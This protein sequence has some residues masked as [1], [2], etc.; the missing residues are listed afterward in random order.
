[1]PMPVAFF[2]AYP[3]F[4]GSELLPRILERD[5]DLAAVCVVQPKFASLARARVQAL[6]GSHPSLEGRVRI[7]EGDITLPSLGLD[8]HLALAAEVTQIFHLAAVYDLSV[9]RELALR[10]NVEGTRNVIRFAR[11]CPALQRLQ[12]V[13]TCYVSGRY[14]G[15]FR[16]SQLEEG[17]QFNN[18][19]EET[20]FL[21][22]V[23][24]RRAMEE[25]LPTTIYR[26]S[27]VV[28]DSRTGATQ[29]FDGPYFAIQW[30]LRQPKVAAMPVFGDP[31]ATEFNVV[32]RDFVLDAITHLSGRPDAVGEVFQ[33]ADPAPLTVDQL[34]RELARATDRRIVR[35]PLPL[36]VAKGAVAKVPGVYRLMRIPA[37]SIDYMVHPTRYATDRARAFLDPVGIR[38]PPLPEYLDRL[39]HFARAHPEIG[40]AAMA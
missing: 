31:R 11:A 1:M 2:T 36:R 26:P 37:S 6:V 27:I 15:V 19:Y 10:V 30:L 39:V 3:G 34:I 23:E 29:K 17:Q 16:E 35:L 32:P 20:K 13:S 40:S 22:E 8:E 4:L 21:A 14:R 24:V 9:G 5:D 33:L 28:G 12:Y 18:F 38:V 7:L 25:G